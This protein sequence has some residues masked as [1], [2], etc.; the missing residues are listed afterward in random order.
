MTAPSAM[1]R[2]VALRSVAVRRRTKTARRPRYASTDCRAALRGPQRA[3]CGTRACPLK[4]FGRGGY[5]STSLRVPLRLAVA[6]SPTRSVSLTR[7]AASVFPFRLDWRRAA[8]QWAR[9]PRQWLTTARRCR[10]LRFPL[11]LYT[12]ASHCNA[13]YNT[14]IYYLVL[15]CR[16]R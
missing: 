15:R 13:A 5:E 16:Y 4:P 6:P 7:C 3:R 12:K 9:R 2:R 14:R 1:A 11:Y 10:F 8:Y